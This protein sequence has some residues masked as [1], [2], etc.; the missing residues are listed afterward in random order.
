MLHNL[1]DWHR[2]YLSNVRS[3]LRFVYICHFYFPFSHAFIRE[4][5][6]AREQ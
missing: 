1:V 5:V 2:F 4:D 3:P 6:F